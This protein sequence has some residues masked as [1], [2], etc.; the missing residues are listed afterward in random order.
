MVDCRPSFR[1]FGALLTMTR[2]QAPSI[3]D[4]MMT[5]I[6]PEAPREQISGLTEVTQVS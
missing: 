5:N 6:E 3:D 1:S 4:L 2:P